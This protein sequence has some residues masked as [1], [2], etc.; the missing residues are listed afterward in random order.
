MHP[1]Y[2]TPEMSYEAGEI[3]A[4]NDLLDALAAALLPAA[5]RAFSDAIVRHSAQAGADIL[6]GEALSTL[7]GLLAE[8]DGQ[9][10]QPGTSPE[11]PRRHGQL[12]HEMRRL[13]AG[14]AEALAAPSDPA[15]W[16]LPDMRSWVLARAMN[17]ARA[18]A[19]FWVNLGDSTAARHAACAAFLP[20]LARQES[21]AGGMRQHW[22][23]ICSRHYLDAA[24]AGVLLAQADRHGLQREARH[25]AMAQ[26]RTASEQYAPSFAMTGAAMSQ[27]AQWRARRS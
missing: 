11:A 22:Q 5:E 12:D 10:P 16:D 26:P 13:S 7:E 18:I 14:L 21:G 3:S 20:T 24:Q 27:Q 25:G 23:L 9:D 1:N 8:L 2:R 19:A 4:C 17:L 6:A 15:G